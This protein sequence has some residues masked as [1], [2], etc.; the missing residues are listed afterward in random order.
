MKN[1]SI[2]TFF[3]STGAFRYGH[4]EVNAQIYRIDDNLQEIAA[5]HLSLRESYYNPTALDSGKKR[6]KIGYQN[7]F[8]Q[9]L[10]VFQ[11]IFLILGNEKKF[12]GKFLNEPS[13]T[14]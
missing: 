11:N 3:L 8:I 10:K 13:K 12:G 5:G 4:S 1:N 6:G 2:L 9:K 7:L 14:L